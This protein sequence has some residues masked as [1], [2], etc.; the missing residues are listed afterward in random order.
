MSASAADDVSVD[1]DPVRSLDRLL[2]TAAE[3][4]DALA[5]STSLVRQLT[6]SGDL[7]CR[8]IGR[9]V[10]YAAVDIEAFVHSYD[11]RGYQ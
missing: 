2:F 5:V 7:P 9:L 3:V 11:E 4:A 6:L 8:R 10:R 1:V